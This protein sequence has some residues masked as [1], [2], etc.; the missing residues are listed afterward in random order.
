M[1][2]KFTFLCLTICLTVQFQVALACVDPTPP[3][4]KVNTK[5]DST[6]THVEFTIKDLKTAGGTAGEYCTCGYYAIQNWIDN[7][8]YVAFVD[9]GTTNPIPFFNPWGANNSAS[10]AWSALFPNGNSPAAFVAD[11]TSG[12]MPTNVPVDLIIKGTLKSWVTKLFLDSVYSNPSELTLGTDAFDYNLGVLGN[13]HQAVRTLDNSGGYTEVPAAYFSNS[14]D[15][16]AVAHQILFVPNPAKDKIVFPRLTNG[17]EYNLT[18]MDSKGAAVLIQNVSFNKSTVALDN[19]VEGLYL[20]SLVSGE[21]KITQKLL[22][23]KK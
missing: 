19:L 15:E 9:S 18:I 10:V 16:S 12:G 1:K 4:P 14:I 3:A 22:V 23:E 17:K 5:V 7:I 21:E 11:V 6:F 13:M 8:Y 2:K 20:I